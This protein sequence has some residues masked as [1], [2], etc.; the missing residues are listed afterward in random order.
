MISNNG[1]NVIVGIIN[2]SG[3]NGIDCKTSRVG[4]GFTSFENPDKINTKIKVN[5]MISLYTETSLIQLNL[6]KTLHEL[7]RL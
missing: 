6:K 4:R 2:R 1:K 7:P 3:N 5:L